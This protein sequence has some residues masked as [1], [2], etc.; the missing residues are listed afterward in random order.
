MGK[1]ERNIK[2]IHKL[3]D[4]K[5]CIDYISGLSVETIKEQRKLSLSVRRLFQILYDNSLFINPR[6]AWPK[7]RRLQLRQQILQDSTQK[8]SKD[9]LDQLNDLD[10]AIEGNTPLID[11]SIHITTITKEEKTE[12][13]N[14]IRL[15]FADKIGE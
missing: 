2:G 14:R 4:Y 5:I 15:L 6:I 7:T 10:R 8:T 11:N 3:R 9:I 13:G 1:I 12:R